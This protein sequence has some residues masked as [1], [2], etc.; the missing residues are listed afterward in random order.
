MT[1]PGVSRIPSITFSTNDSVKSSW[2]FE[3]FFIKLVSCASSSFRI[4]VITALISSPV[5]SVSDF[6]SLFLSSLEAFCEL[7]L[8]FFYTAILHQINHAINIFKN[9][10]LLF[11]SN[12]ILRIIFVIRLLIK[13]RHKLAL[14][15]DLI[16]RNHNNMTIQIV[17]YTLDDRG[18]AGAWR[19]MQPNP[20]C[21]RH[22]IVFVPMLIIN[23]KNRAC[24]VS[25]LCCRKTSRYRTAYAN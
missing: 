12:R 8:F 23:K 4:S 11:K 14:C 22:T 9:N 19:S 25:T 20:Q 15:L 16:Q 2:S 13:C 17:G 18:L 7:V 24:P 5:F 1:R 3:V 6:S 10:D 21:V